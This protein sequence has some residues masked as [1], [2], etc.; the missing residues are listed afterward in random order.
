M[1]KNWD[2]IA[3]SVSPQIWSSLSCDHSCFGVMF[4]WLIWKLLAKL[5]LTFG[6]VQC[7]VE[8]TSL[9]EIGARSRG[10]HEQ[11]GCPRMCK[12]VWR[13]GRCFGLALCMEQGL[14]WFY[15]HSKGQDSLANIWF[16][17]IWVEHWWVSPGPDFNHTASASHK[18]KREGQR[19][20]Y[21]RTMACLLFI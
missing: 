19:G 1:H 7:W 10:D 4:D 13:E 18:P 17:H 8:K 2:A 5:S 21:P 9:W 20:A 11:C 14:S 3:S 12:K 16:I 6:D 15:L